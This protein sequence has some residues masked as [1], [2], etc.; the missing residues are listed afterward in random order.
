MHLSECTGNRGR[1]Q[2]AASCVYRHSNA[3]TIDPCVTKLKWRTPKHWKFPAP[4]LHPYYK[5]KCRLY[6][7]MFSWSH[8][9]RYYHRVSIRC[10]V[11]PDTP[12]SINHRQETL[13]LGH[14]A[15]EAQ[16]M[17][18]GKIAL[19]YTGYSFVLLEVTCSPRGLAVHMQIFET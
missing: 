3:S 9:G 1:V 5:C 15:L 4:S 10:F 18:N 19:I 14:L 7:L 12:Y 8:L 2:L 13:H 11:I 6:S 16:H 17:P